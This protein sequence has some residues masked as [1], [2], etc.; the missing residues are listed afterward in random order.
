MARVSNVHKWRWQ[1]TLRTV[2][3]WLAN[4]FNLPNEK[5]VTFIDPTAAYIYP[6]AIEIGEG[7]IIEPNVWIS[8]KTKIGKRCRIEFGSVIIDSELEDD[9]AVSGGCIEKSWIGSHAKIGYT[10]QIKRTRFGAYSK[11]IHHGY[12]G[13]AIV[14]ERV[15]IGAGVITANYDGFKKHLTIIENDAFIGTNVCLVAPIRV[16]EGVMIAAGS[17]VTANDHLEPWRLVIARAPAHLSKSK[18]VVKDDDGWHLETRE[19]EK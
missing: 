7:T 11:M 8:G 14:G 16:P 10:A 6:P 5:I 3:A 18:R 1:K 4:G 15:N 12:L 19:E 9:V 2:G 17:T 13:D